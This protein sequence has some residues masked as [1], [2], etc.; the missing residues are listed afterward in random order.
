MSS[1]ASNP[2]RARQTELL[3]ARLTFISLGVQHIADTERMVRAVVDDARDAGATWQQI[4]D[5]L[6]IGQEAARKRYH[7]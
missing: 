2:Y 3:R 6:G 4:G 5:A 1:A 7:P